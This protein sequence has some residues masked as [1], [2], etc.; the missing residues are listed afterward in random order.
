MV[1][2]TD[3]S[4]KPI[5]SSSH[6]H[7]VLHIKRKDIGITNR[8]DVDN[9]AHVQQRSQTQVEHLH[10]VHP[11]NLFPQQRSVGVMV[12]VNNELNLINA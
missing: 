6:E 1:T 10:T 4:Y 12:N 5:N 2:K 11:R 3:E 8:Q 9:S 7:V